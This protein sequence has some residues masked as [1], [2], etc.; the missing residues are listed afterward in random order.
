METKI[1]NQT[2]LH[3]RPAATFVSKAATFSADIT[4]QNLNTGREANVKSIVGIL[5]LG[6]FKDTPVKISA[7]GGDE[8]EAVKALVELVEGGF[9]DT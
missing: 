2:G 7:V 9:G 3:A 6:L 8:S 1:I 5:T 4:I